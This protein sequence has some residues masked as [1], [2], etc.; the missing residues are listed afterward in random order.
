VLLREFECG[1]AIVNGHTEAVVVDLSAAAPALRRLDGQQAPRVQLIVDDASAAFHPGAGAWAVGSR[2]A[3]L[4]AEI[5][6]KA[7]RREAKES[8]L[9]AATV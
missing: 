6:F 2:S 3:A 8:R 5:A 7:L 1:V 9:L 4:K